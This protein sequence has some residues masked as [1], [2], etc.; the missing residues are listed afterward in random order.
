M[1]VCACV[2]CLLYECINLGVWCVWHAYTCNTYFTI[3]RLL[4]WKNF[5]SLKKNRD[6]K[7]LKGKQISNSC[8]SHIYA[9]HASSRL[10]EDIFLIAFQFAGVNHR[11]EKDSSENITLQN[12]GSKLICYSGMK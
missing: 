2:T 6:Q 12:R 7:H 1:W 4:L 10:D 8:K 5:R 9:N 11:L 3:K